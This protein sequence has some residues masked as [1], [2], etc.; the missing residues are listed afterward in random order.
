MPHFTKHQSNCPRLC[1]DMWFSLGLL[2]YSCGVSQRGIPSLLLG[3]LS[4]ASITFL[5]H[6][7]VTEGAWGCP[8]NTL[9]VLLA[10]ATGAPAALI[11]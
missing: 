6:P 3:Q 9:F 11:C 2:L 4:L 8:L 5:C 7:A 10:L 1:L